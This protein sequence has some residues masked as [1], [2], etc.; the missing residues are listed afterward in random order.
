[1]GM[2]T[3]RARRVGLSDK[4]ANKCLGSTHFSKWFP[5]KA[6]VRASSRHLGNLE[7][8]KET[9]ARCDRKRNRPIFFMRR[10]LNGKIGKQ[11]G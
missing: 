5:L 7:L 8:Y 6:G 4:F 11:Y 10:R 2:E 9:F 3:L 1:M